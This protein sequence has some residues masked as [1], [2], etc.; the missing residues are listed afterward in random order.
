MKEQIILMAD[1]IGSSGKDQ[2]Q[3]MTDFAEIVTETNRV[4][5]GQLLSP[6][7]ITLGDEF[8]GVPKGLP[9]AI[10]LIQ[11][12]EEALLRTGKNFRLRYV[13]VE[14]LIETPINPKIA[15]GMLGDG[16][17]RARKYLDELKNTDARFFFWVR[18]QAQKKALNNV[19]TALQ[20][21]TGGWN[22]EKDYDLV[23]AFLR[24]G[25]YKKVA[26]ALKKDRSLVWKR[27]R[28][29]QIDAYLALQEVAGYIGGN[30][31]A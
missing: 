30:P 10:V 20:T 25:D 4:N 1:I 2:R 13:V 3:L 22:S 12:L 8:Q 5:P 26:E 11:Y 31:H 24:Y 29:L 27:Q 17:T 23:S 18:D 19:F 28:S 9:E 6:L 7:T 14:G 15:Y 16:L 21:I